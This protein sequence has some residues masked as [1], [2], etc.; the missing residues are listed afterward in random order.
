[1]C[2]G[3]MRAM[4]TMKRTRRRRE[5]GKRNYLKTNGERGNIM[6]ETVSI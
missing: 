5:G 1:M 4:S 3:G 6:N 2:K